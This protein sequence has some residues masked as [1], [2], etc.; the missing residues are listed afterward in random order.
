MTFEY[1]HEGPCVAPAIT[2]IRP[3]E[4]DPGGKLLPES[5]LST[6]PQDLPAV[7]PAPLQC[8]S[9]KWICSLGRNPPKILQ[10]N[11]PSRCRHDIGEGHSG[12]T[13]NGVLMELEPWS[14][15]WVDVK[16]SKKTPRISH[17]ADLV[18]SKDPART[19]PPCQR[20]LRPPKAP[21]LRK[22][23]IR[24]QPP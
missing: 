17:A 3:R 9:E 4:R 14:K 19:P 8:D 10:D 1:P 13:A 16:S 24:R 21:S 7:G 2:S 20:F 15:I 5:Q 23:Q 11:L 22:Q 18:D 12:E 6:K